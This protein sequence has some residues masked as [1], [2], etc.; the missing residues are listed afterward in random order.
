MCGQDYAPWS[1]WVFRRDH[2]C[3]V[4]GTVW[5]NSDESIFFYVPV[6]PAKG[7]DEVIADERV[8]FG[9]GYISAD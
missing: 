8:V 7:G 5:R 9:I 1:V 4:F 6:E 2:I 3:E